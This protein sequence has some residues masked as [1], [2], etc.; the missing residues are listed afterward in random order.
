MAVA[1]AHLVAAQERRRPAIGRVG[2]DV[3]AAEGVLR[4]VADRQMGIRRRRCGDRGGD[5]AGG[6]EGEGELA[7]SHEASRGC[8]QALR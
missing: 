3:G 6:R 4:L 2:H 7:R 1:E 8:L 5:Q